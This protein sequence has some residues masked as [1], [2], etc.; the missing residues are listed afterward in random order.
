MTPASA[1]PASPEGRGRFYRGKSMLAVFRPGDHLDVRPVSL[2]EV[3]RGDVVLFRPLQPGREDDVVVHR[4]VA[5]LPEGLVT[6]GDTNRRPDVPLVTAANLLGRVVARERKGWRLPVLGGEAGLALVRLLL[7]LRRVSRRARR[8]LLPLGRGAWRRL[9]ASPL[10]R[11][12]WR[13]EIVHVRFQ[14]TEGPVVKYVHRGRT[15]A[16]F[17]P[18]AGRF[19]CRRPYDLILTR[20]DARPPS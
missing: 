15:V 4:V 18:E 12:L 17:W 13:P 2:P 9:R 19:R 11:S 16:V 3:R 5:V 20:P 6:R 7:G 1:S 10:L 14:S 8:A